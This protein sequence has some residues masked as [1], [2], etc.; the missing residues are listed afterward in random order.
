VRC[1]AC[2]ID[3]GEIRFDPH[4]GA[5]DSPTWFMRVLEG[6]HFAKKGDGRTSKAQKKIIKEELQRSD[7]AANHHNLYPDEPDPEA[8]EWCKRWV[9]KHKLCCAVEPG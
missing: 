1:P 2:G 5:R 4:P 3:A 7:A 9:L 8:M 6:V